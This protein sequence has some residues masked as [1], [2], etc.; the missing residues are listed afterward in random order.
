MVQLSENLLLDYGRAIY[1]FT[2]ILKGGLGFP[3]SYTGY[4]RIHN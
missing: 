4:R 2:R 3:D 1:K